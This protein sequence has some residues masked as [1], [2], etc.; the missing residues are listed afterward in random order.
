VYID[1][2]DAMI[3]LLPETGTTGFKLQTETLADTNT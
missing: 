2:R 1:M 3:M